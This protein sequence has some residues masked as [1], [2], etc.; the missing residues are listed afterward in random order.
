M[1]VMSQPSVPRLVRDEE[2]QREV[3]LGVTEKR[4]VLGDGHLGAEIHAL[5]EPGR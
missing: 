2:K 1:P 3:L 4:P 5:L